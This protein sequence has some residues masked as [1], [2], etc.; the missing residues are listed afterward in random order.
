MINQSIKIAALAA[1]FTI[2]ANVVSGQAQ[3]APSSVRHDLSEICTDG[4]CVWEKHITCSGFIEGINFDKDGTMW[5]VGYLGG[6]IFKVEDGKCVS[7]GETM[8]APNGA[9]F[10]PNGNLIVADRLGGIQSV[11]PKTGKRT[12]IHSQYVTAQF[13]GLNDLVFDS[14][15]GYYFTEPYGSDALNKVGRVFYV[16]PGEDSKP[17]VFVEGMAYPNGIAVSADGQKVF[18]SEFAE[19][20][21]LVVPSKHSKNIFATPLVFARLVGGIGPDGLTVDSE[22]N[23]YVAHFGAGEVAIFDASGFPYGIIRLPEG[24]APFSTNLVIHDGYLYV[25]EAIKN[26]VWRLPITKAPL[27][28]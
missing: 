2:G 10:A 5:M 24:A 6:N 25:T 11:D 1:M 9:K 3:M 16:A 28:K 14:T 8:G 22:G 12:Q 13:R 17:E 21:V 20:R 15:G 7:V 26:E 23:L 4:K 27:V 19:N 18:I